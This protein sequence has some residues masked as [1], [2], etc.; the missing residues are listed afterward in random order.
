MGWKIVFFSQGYGK[1]H[2]KRDLLISKRLIR[3]DDR[4]EVKFASYGEGY[5]AAIGEGLQC[6]NLGLDI[7]D[8]I[9]RIEK[10]LCEEKP[11]LVVTD[12]ELIA[13]PLS[14]ARKIP[15]LLITNWL[16]PH[17]NHPAVKYFADADG[18]ILAHLKECFHL[19]FNLKTPLHFVGP[20]F[21]PLKRGAEEKTS[22]G[23][24]KLAIVLPRLSHDS[25]DFL[26]NLLEM[27]RKL[28]GGIHWL[29]LAGE[30]KEELKREYE[31][32]SFEF[33]NHLW[34]LDQY[35]L[36][37][38]FVV[39]SPRFFILWQLAE[40]GIPSMCV[41][42]PNSEYLVQH[43]FLVNCIKEIGYVLPLFEGEDRGKIK[44][45][46]EFLVSYRTHSEGVKIQ[47]RQSE[48]RAAEII[49]SFLK[50]GVNAK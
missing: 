35:L 5:K 46:L 6:V 20:L 26:R 14:K 15:S 10:L 13:L 38:S 28:D 23:K 2:L 31:E 8:R 7:H 41:L 50:E 37:S 34:G 17:P 18:I 42:H 33:R 29:V 19:P 32:G 39:T 45:S 22:A 49:V 1:D 44:E 4:I 36:S 24:A 40:L 12:E 48:R 11:D 47:R 30:F 25:L 21:H 16:P 3:K 43:L 27:A 9:A